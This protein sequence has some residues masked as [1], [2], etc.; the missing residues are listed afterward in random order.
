VG[1]IAS[2]AQFDELAARLAALGIQDAR[3]A[4]D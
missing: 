2:V 3:L 4:P 1:P